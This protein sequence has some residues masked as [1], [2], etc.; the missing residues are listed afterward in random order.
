L[1][2]ALSLRRPQLHHHRA[3]VVARIVGES[4]A[5]RPDIHLV[6]QRNDRDVLDRQARGAA[7]L[8]ASSMSTPMPAMVW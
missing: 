4:L 3:F 7:I 8:L 2:A 5:R 6:V 1:A